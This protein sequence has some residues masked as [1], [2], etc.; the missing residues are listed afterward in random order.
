MGVSL[1][2]RGEVECVNRR[3]QNLPG[4]EVGKEMASV[5][6]L[7]ESIWPRYRGKLAGLGQ[8]CPCG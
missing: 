8:A 5:G 3:G 6:N 4:S 2:K 1:A 7:G